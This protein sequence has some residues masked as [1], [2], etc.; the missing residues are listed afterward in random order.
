MRLQLACLLSCHCLRQCNYAERWLQP[1][2]SLKCT[3]TSTKPPQHATGFLLC[4]RA[5]SLPAGGWSHLQQLFGL[6]KGSHTL[7][8]A[9]KVPH[10]TSHLILRLLQQVAAAAAAQGLRLDVPCALPESQGSEDVAD[11][12]S[13]QE[14]HA[15]HN[16]P[17]YL[18]VMHSV[19]VK[20]ACHSATVGAS[21]A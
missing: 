18:S 16:G 4:L 15:G 17:T 6:M 13:Q 5:W 9:Q 8:S 1:T 20:V 10:S 3:K 7:L 2:W 21:K 14:Q 11:L 12:Q 19:S